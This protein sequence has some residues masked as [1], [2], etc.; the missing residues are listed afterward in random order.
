VRHPFDRHTTLLH[1]FKKC[2]LGT[3]HGAIEFVDQKDV[4]KNRAG[5]KTEI[6]GSAIEDRQTGYIGG[7]EITGTLHPAEKEAGRARQGQSQGRLAEAGTI[8]QQQVP[9][10]KQGNDR[11]L[12]GIVLAGKM[13]AVEGGE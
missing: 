7:E 5:D 3:G 1:R 10:A 13:L 8:F 11:Q 2:A 12:Q 4:A 9:A 6:V